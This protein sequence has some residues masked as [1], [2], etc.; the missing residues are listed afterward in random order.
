M[1]EK[2][3]ERSHNGCRNNVKELIQYTIDFEKVMEEEKERDSGGERERVI[4][5]TT[6]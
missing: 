5:N 1:I 4:V 6:G 2:G 3:L